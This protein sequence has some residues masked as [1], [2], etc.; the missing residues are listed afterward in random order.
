MESLGGKKSWKQSIL[1]LD[2]PLADYDL[3]CSVLLQSTQSAV[4]SS[5]SNTS[6]CN[7][8]SPS[9]QVL[10]GQSTSGSV[11]LSSPCN[12]GSFVG[13]MCYADDIVLLAPCASA[14]RIL[15][16]VCESYAVSHGQCQ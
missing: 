3:F 10:S 9:S 14:L 15:L 7:V 12:P 13:A 5:L 8:L 6:S 11:H 2:K 16:S 1:H 4:D